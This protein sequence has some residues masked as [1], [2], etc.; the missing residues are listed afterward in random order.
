M[1]VSEKEL[2]GK[3]RRTCKKR[4]RTLYRAL[5]ITFAYSLAVT[6][7]L[8]AKRIPIQILCSLKKSRKLTLRKLR[9]RVLFRT[10]S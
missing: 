9:I 3:E 1:F 7:N 8:S 10:F 6:M 2:F 5:K 4:I